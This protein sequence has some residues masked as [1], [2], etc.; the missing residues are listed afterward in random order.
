MALQD[1]IVIF[2]STLLLLAGYSFLYRENVWFNFAET[3]LVAVTLGNAVSQAIVTVNN[4]GVTPIMNGSNLLLIVPMILGAL[5]LLRYIPKLRWLGNWAL[6]FTIG[7]GIG[8]SLR[9]LFQQSII[10]QIQPLFSMI[11]SGDWSQWFIVL[12]VVT[13]MIYFLYTTTGT[14][15]KVT[16]NVGRVGRLIFMLA[17]GYGLASM[18]QQRISR[19]G[20]VIYQII[21]DQPKQGFT[22]ESYAALVIAI[23]AVAVDAVY[24]RY[25]ELQRK[26]A[27]VAATQP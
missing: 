17:L 12:T 13:M 24:R 2:Y 7:S 10:S 9:N 21:I 6:A 19:V 16:T 22:I 8:L 3:S 20:S 25:K 15:G 27:K 4:S 5:A 1:S 11:G 23:G 18:T 14:A 26:G